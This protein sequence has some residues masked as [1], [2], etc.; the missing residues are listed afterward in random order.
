MATRTRSQTGESTENFVQQNLLKNPEKEICAFDNADI[1]ALRASGAFP[2]KAII[3]PF[4]RTIRSDVS[5]GEWICFSAYPFSLGL[6]YPFPE[7]MMQV[8]RKTGLSFSQMM[9]M[10]WRVLIVLNQIKALHVPNICIEDIP[11]AYR[12]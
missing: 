9:P 7:F 10:V 12:L 6:R 5:S 2:D 8:F 1:A 4:D 11:I 3:R